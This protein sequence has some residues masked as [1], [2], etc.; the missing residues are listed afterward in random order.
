MGQNESNCKREIYGN[1][2]PYHE[3]WTT[4]NK[5]LNVKSQTSR[6]ISQTQNSYVGGNYEDQSINYYSRDYDNS[7]QIQ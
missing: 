6:K 3:N 7:R 1:E 4:S 2:Y 5:K